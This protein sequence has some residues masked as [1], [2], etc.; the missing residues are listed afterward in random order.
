MKFMQYINEE[1]LLGLTLRGI[2]P[3]EFE[4][5]CLNEF[6]RHPHIKYYTND[7]NFKRFVICRD[8]HIELISELKNGMTYK[9]GILD[10]NIHEIPEWVKETKGVL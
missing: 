2:K 5:S 4:F 6:L 8:G 1:Y 7:T 9:I 3:V 10:G